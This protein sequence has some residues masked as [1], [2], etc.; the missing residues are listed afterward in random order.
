MASERYAPP[1]DAR[2]AGVLA[3]DLEAWLSL[4]ATRGGSGWREVIGMCCH[5]LARADAHVFDAARAA[6]LAEGI[7]GAS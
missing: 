2:A 1:A 4:A 6:Q 5:C 7:R 3:E